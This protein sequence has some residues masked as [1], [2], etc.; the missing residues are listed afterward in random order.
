MNHK[1]VLL[2][3][4]NM[5]LALLLVSAC[6][7][8]QPTAPPPIA[9]S[10]PT[11]TPEPSTVTPE[12]TPNA[13][14]TG[15]LWYIPFVSGDIERKYHLYIPSNYHP[16]Q[17]YPLVLYIH[18]AS[19]G[20]FA[21]QA[22]I[23]WLPLAEEI[24]FI[25]LAPHP[26]DGV[27]WRDGDPGWPPDDLT[28]ASYVTSFANL[29]DA[30]LTEIVTLSNPGTIIRT[31]THY[32]GDLT[33]AEPI[34]YFDEDLR[35]FIEPVN[36]EILQIAAAHIVPVARVDIAFNGLTGEEDPV[37]KGYLAADTLHTTQLGAAKIAETH[38]ALGYEPTV[39]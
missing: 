33:K 32:Y 19:G 4:M 34:F 5:G 21:L 7:T 28:G 16:D 13:V 31:M 26:V 1:K 20:G 22:N 38:R 39:P 9:T 30:I 29:Y 37:A 6:S 2:W 11:A 35:P 12:P 17:S 14:Q 3:I 8:P 18:W 10:A 24:G 27:W 23:G 15:S 25:L 36:E